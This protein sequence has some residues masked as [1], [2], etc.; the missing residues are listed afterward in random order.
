V[1]T[2]D[3]VWQAASVIVAHARHYGG[4]FVFAPAA[5]LERATLQVCLFERA[6]RLATIGYALALVTGRLPAL[7]SYRTVA[8]HRI[9]IRG[10]A[11][12]PLQGD[13]DIIGRL[14][15]TIEVLP[16]ALDLV[17]PPRPS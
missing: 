13:G 17:Y 6:G 8:A 5:G 1:Q 2:D 4:R 15:A 10:R 12:E 16:D 7:A 14:N 3:A 9:E 11:G